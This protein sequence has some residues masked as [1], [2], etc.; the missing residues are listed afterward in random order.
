MIGFEPVA[1]RMVG[2]NVAGFFDRVV[3]RRHRPASSPI[4]LGLAFVVLL[5]RFLYQR[6]IF[7]R[8]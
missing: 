2:G 5:A 8:V 7:L 6:Q 3:A 1:M 4:S